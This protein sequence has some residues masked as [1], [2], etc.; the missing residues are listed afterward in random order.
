MQTHARKHEKPDRHKTGWYDDTAA[1]RRGSTD[2]ES[3]QVSAGVLPKLESSSEARI[4]G[5]V[6]C[7][8]SVWHID[9]KKY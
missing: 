4:R 3:E 5:A 7:A 9:M 2:A 1:A 6:S 8:K